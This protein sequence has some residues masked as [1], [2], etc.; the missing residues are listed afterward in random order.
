MPTHILVVDDDETLREVVSAMMEGEGRIVDTAASGADCLAFVAERRPD[1]MLLD[2]TMPEM[3]GWDVIERLKDHSSPPAVVAMSG[4]DMGSSDLFAVRP[5]VYGFLSKP[6]SQ[7]QLVK[8]CLR[9]LEAAQAS[10]GSVQAFQDRRADPRR[11]IVVPAQLLTPEGT[12]AA[13]GQILNLNARGAELDLGGSLKPGMKLALAFE[14]P[15]A[16]GPF[17]VTARVEWKKDGKLGLSFVDV[18]KE[19][20]QRLA[21]VL[22]AS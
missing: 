14:I 11:N 12:P 5:F 10:G 20:R 7:E 17:R 15:G 16:Q 18:P 9:A 13:Q 1:L 4:M 3:S 22:T 6:F 21:E 8:T 2:L 19:D